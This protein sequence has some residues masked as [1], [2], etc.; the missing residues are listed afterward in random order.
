SILIAVHPLPVLKE[1]HLASSGT[2]AIVADCSIAAKRLCAPLCA[3]LC[4]LCLEHPSAM[5]HTGTKDCSCYGNVRRPD[6]GNAKENCN[7]TSHD[8][9]DAAAAVGAA[10]GRLWF[11]YRPGDSAHYATSRNAYHATSRN[12]YHA[13][14]RWDHQRHHLWAGGKHSI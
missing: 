10:D 8:R 4:A 11:Q 2:S 7:E 1:R 13:A 12:A 6:L 5:R 3:P 14:V 9:L